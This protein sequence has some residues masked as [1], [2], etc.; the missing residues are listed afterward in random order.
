LAF[1]GRSDTLNTPRTGNFLG[2]VQLLDKFDP[3]M[4]EHLWSVVNHET[5][6]HYFCKNIQSELIDLLGNEIRDTIILE[7]KRSKYF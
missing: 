3:V 7:I 2:L 4:I 6:N 1:R 5:K